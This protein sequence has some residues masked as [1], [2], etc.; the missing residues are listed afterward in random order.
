MA[1]VSSRKKLEHLKI[2]PELEL[3][4]L[5]S[6]KKYQESSEQTGNI[7]LAEYRCIQKENRNHLPESIYSKLRVLNSKLEDDITLLE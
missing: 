7:T 1:K 4:I 2:L 6:D 3:K 5:Q